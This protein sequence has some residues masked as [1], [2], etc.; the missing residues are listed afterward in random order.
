MF[1]LKKIVSQFLFPLPIGAS[2]LVAGVLLLWLSKRQK[3]GKV[4]VTIGA[5]FLL[6]LSYGA[7]SNRLLAPLETLYPTYDLWRASDTVRAEQAFAYVVVLGGGHSSDPRLPPSSQLSAASLVRLVEGIR[8][9]REH[10]GSTLVLTGGTVFDPVPEAETMYALAVQLGVD[11]ADLVAE[12]G[13]RDT[14]DQARIIQAMVGDQPFVLVTSAAHMPRS[15]ALFRKQGADPVPAPTGHMVK[16]SAA[17]KW[18]P[19]PR[20]F[21]P[22][23]TDLRKAEIAIYEYMGIVWGRLRNLL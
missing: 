2:L 7:A 1:L 18:S 4:L 13:S 20:D 12:S 11:P 21:F 19:S 15:M 6:T 17:A 8:I 9:H 14:K 16:G 5:L 23:G 10:P 22:N 3:L